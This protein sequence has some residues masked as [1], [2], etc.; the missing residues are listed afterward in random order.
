[1]KSDHHQLA[2][3]WTLWYT[4][5]N[6][7]HNK[8]DEYESTIK[9]GCDFSTI[10]EFWAAYQHIIRPCELSN[11]GIQT[12]YH[13]FKKGI[14]PLW[15]DP[16]NRQGGKWSI[17]C[18]KPFSSKLWEDL[19]ISL[20][21]EQFNLGNEICGGVVS[22]R[23]YNDVIAVWS[24]TA[25]DKNILEKRIRRVLGFPDSIHMEYKEHNKALQ[26][27][28]ITHVKEDTYHEETTKE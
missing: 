7:E 27:A 18:K 19:I 23:P 1:M 20:I 13:L 4:D 24:R 17:R 2:R 10:E 14:K 21:G 12:D 25:A 26:S 16:A 22:I 6:S 15:E 5:W 3:S 11:R 9:E 28:A 8:K